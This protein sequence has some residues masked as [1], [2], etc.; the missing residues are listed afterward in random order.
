[1]FQ[2]QVT[3][4]QAVRSAIQQHYCD[5][6]G[7]ASRS[8]YWWFALFTLILSVIIQ[9]FGVI[10]S[11]VSLYLSAI[12][13]L[14]LFLPGLSL[15]VRR[16]HDINKSGWYILLVLIPIVGLIILLVWFCKESEMQPNKYGPVPNVD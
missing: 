10:S 3:F 15:D 2:R 9:A 1:M 11:D 14:A 7:R 8:E 16:L 6:S 12:V 5:F 4:E 13:N